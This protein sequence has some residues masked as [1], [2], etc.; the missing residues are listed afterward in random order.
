MSIFVIY[1]KPFSIINSEGFIPIQAGAKNAK[2]K[3]AMIGDDTDD[4]ISEKNPYFCELTVQ[5]WAWKNWQ[6]DYYGFFHY[7][8]F[9]NFSSYKLFGANYEKFDDKTIKKYG[10]HKAKID[11]LMKENDILLPNKTF[12]YGKLFKKQ[13][14]EEHYCAYHN[15]KD[16][17]IIKNI[18][19]SKTPSFADAWAKTISKT[20]AYC[21]NIFV[22]KKDVFREY[23]EWLFKILF[24]A[25]NKIF[26]DKEHP[27]QKRVFGF[28]AE[29]LFNVYL[30][31]LFEK[32]PNI[33]TKKFQVCTA[34]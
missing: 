30:E 13:T 25:E 17:E 7:R 19:F 3:L 20:N 1:H 9:L 31:Y 2:E 24:E 33:K 10:W 14:M 32:S 5:Y 8:R 16:L 22:M 28:L 27:Y 6:S 21:F 18:I 29:R 26:V 12:F 34:K 4:N 11:S 15:K 23:M